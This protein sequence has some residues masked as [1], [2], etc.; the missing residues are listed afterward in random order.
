V[1]FLIDAQLPPALAR[2]L[3]AHGHQAEHVSDIGRGDAPDRELWHYAVE[4]DAVL[5][6]KDEDF[7]DMV[8]LGDPAPVV[9]WVRVG[10]T[11][12]QA[13]LEWFGPLIDRIVAMAST[14]D[15]L[16]ELR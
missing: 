5:V 9:V 15:R 6:T 14:G 13:L 3:T 1:R 16:I 7:T 4:H 10:N 2:L 8:L 11:R 12:K